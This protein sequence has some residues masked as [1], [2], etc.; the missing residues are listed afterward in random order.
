MEERPDE[1]IYVERVLYVYVHVL[2]LSR[3][4]T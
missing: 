2:T 3:V 4:L 1:V